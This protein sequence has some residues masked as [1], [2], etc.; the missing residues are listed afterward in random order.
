MK[1]QKV[2]DTKVQLEVVEPVQNVQISAP[3]AVVNEEKKVQSTP[4]KKVIRAEPIKSTPKKATPK[5]TK[6]LVKEE[7]KQKVEDDTSTK[8]SSPYEIK[9]MLE[10]TVL[11]RETLIESIQFPDGRNS[12]KILQYIRE[13]SISSVKKIQSSIQRIKATEKKLKELQKKT[14]D[15]LKRK[16]V[17]LETKHR[18]SRH[19]GRWLFY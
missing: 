7:A 16:G 5:S 4:T 8:I 2:S 1:R 12:V 6:K 15:S 9:K 14:K 11:S 3:K 17:S 10:S 19:K 18:H 13:I